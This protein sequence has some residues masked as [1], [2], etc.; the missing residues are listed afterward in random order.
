MGHPV[1]LKYNRAVITAVA[2]LLFI[3][4]CNSQAPATTTATSTATQPPS[5]VTFGQLASAGQAVYASR[6]ASCHGNAGQGAGAPPLWGANS[7]LSDLGN[8][9]LLLSFTSGSMPPGASGTISRQNH[10]EIVA[11]LL[12]Q[13]GWVT[14]TEIF[15]ESQL[16]SILL[17]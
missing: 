2:L 8:A 12:L 10:I 14:Q 15:N 11:Y 4:G 13:N 7:H 5:Q 3:P 16:S 9:Q 6:C 17:R 1:V